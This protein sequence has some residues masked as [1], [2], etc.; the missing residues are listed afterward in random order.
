MYKKPQRDILLHLVDLE[1]LSELDTAVPS[2]Y[3][4]IPI[5]ILPVNTAKWILPSRY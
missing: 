3:C 2:G 5:G 1:R 4:P